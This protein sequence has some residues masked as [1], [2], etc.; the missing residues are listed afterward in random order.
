[1]IFS[2]LLKDDI[3]KLCPHQNSGDE[4][5]PAQAGI[6]RRGIELFELSSEKLISWFRSKARSEV[7]VA[8]VTIGDRL[9]VLSLAPTGASSLRMIP[10]D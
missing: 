8:T 5:L 6:L 4:D 9:S 1:M 2:P 7:N 10:L 3:G